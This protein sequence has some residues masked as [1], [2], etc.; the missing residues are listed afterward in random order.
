[1]QDGPPDTAGLVGARG[2][3]E[4]TVTDLDTA[5]ALGSGEVAV[6]ATPRVLALVEAATVAATAGRLG[7]GMTSVGTQVSLDHLVA[8]PVGRRVTATA[9]L[10]TVEGRRLGFTIEVTDGERVVAAGRIE[11]AVVDT[12]RFLH[13]A[14]AGG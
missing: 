2:R 5:Q 8:T 7:T 9:E 14:Q 1:M 4:H 6:L 10:T 11:R 3:V 13:R 12:A